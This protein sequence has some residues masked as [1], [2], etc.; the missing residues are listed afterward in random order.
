MKARAFK[1]AFILLAICS[2]MMELLS[3][4]FSAIVNYWL[5]DL[6]GTVEGIVIRSELKRSIGGR[7]S[8]R[9]YDIEYEY[10]VD[11][12]T[13]WST[14]V[15]H[16]I[17]GENPH[18]IIDRYSVGKIVL[19]YY[20]TSRPEFSVL[21]NN[22]L[23]AKTYWQLMGLVFLFFLVFFWIRSLNRDQ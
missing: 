19:V 14:R 18:K 4:T 7:L 20:D 12:V 11:G 15:T 8:T 10:K 16:G 6:D 5:A 23:T 2:L 3:G 9:T 22:G 17:S 1:H 13:Y 21:E